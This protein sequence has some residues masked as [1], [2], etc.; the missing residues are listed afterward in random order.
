MG[1]SFDD[2]LIAILL[3]GAGLSVAYVRAEYI[4]WRR[5]GAEQLRRESAQYELHTARLSRRQ[6]AARA[7][8]ALPL[9]KFRI[10][11]AAS[12]DASSAS[13]PSSRNHAQP[14]YVFFERR[15]HPRSGESTRVN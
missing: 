8:R 1:M 2:V 9:R 7:A 3:G 4:R 12:N 13:R 5:S 15:K 10:G 14:S 11:E 6:W